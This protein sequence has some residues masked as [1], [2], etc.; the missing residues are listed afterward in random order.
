MNN[1]LP[2]KIYKNNETGIINLQN[3]NL[4]G[5][6]WVAYKKKGTRTFY[7]DSYGD[8][9]PTQ[10]V[11]KYFQSNGPSII[12]YNYTPYQSLDRVSYNCGHLCILF[13][14]NKL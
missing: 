3:S 4:S 10:E 13:L 9:A 8:L 1:T 11:Q 14:L 5:S 6:H 2:R 7:F 12:V